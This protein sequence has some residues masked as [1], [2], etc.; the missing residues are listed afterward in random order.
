MVRD[1]ES[2]SL[3]PDLLERVERRRRRVEH[4]RVEAFADV[5][6][7]L[8]L[9]EGDDGEVVE[10]ELLQDLQPHVELAAAAVDQD[11]VR[12][13]RPLLQRPRE[14]PR[15][16]LG[17][18]GKVVRA[19]HG[20][21]AEALVVLLLHAPVFPHDQGADLLAA[22]DVRDVVALDPVG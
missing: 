15:E 5:D 4:E 6:F 13:R 1:R 10:A 7:L 11:Q 3:V 8:L 16:N 14:P 19:G 17:E 21:D 9:R 12:Q 18:R 22:L 2:M 20:L